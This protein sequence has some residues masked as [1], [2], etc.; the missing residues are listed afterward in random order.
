MEAYIRDK[1]TA[2]NKTQREGKA[3]DSAGFENWLGP[4][5]ASPLQPV[6]AAPLE[7]PQENH[8]SA[9]AELPAEDSDVSYQ[10]EEPEDAEAEELGL[11]EVESDELES[12]ELESEDH[13]ESL[14]ALESALEDQDFSEAS[15]SWT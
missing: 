2:P 7:A 15:G 1:L 5:E 14:D 9:E 11:Q 4:M 10:A 8:P 12:E 13:Y 6:H 3:L